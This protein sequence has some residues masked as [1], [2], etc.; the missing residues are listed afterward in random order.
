VITGTPVGPAD[1]INFQWDETD[2]VV[3][4]VGAQTYGLNI[5][6]SANE[7]KLQYKISFAFPDDGTAGFFSAISGDSS[8]GS[9]SFTTTDSSG[10]SSTLYGFELSEPGES[11]TPETFYGWMEIGT[12]TSGQVEVCQWAYESTPGAA[13]TVGNASGA[14]EI[15]SFSVDEPT[16]LA[17]VALGLAGLGGASARRAAR[18]ARAL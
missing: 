1:T 17:L 16:P 6:A 5:S 10:E 15:A 14:C 12:T 2:S 9:S 13:I 4:Q 18:L 8:G 11:E 3:A 7:S